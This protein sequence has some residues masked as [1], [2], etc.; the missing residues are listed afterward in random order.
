MVVAGNAERLDTSVD[1]EF[2][3]DTLEL[4]LTRFEVVSAN[5]CL[6]TFSELDASRHECVL[7]RAVDEWAS[8]ED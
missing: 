7:R 1:E 4:G 6:V 5:E 8:F 3:D 2:R